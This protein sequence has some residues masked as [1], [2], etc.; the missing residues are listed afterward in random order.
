MKESMNRIAHN[1][2]SIRT[3]GSVIVFV[4]YNGYNLFADLTMELSALL[5]D[6]I[7]VKKV[8]VYM[9]FNENMDF[10]NTIEFVDTVFYSCGQ[11][12]ALMRR[13]YER[14]VKMFIHYVPEHFNS[15]DTGIYIESLKEKSLA[16]KIPILSIKANSNTYTFDKYLKLIVVPFIEEDC[17]LIHIGMWFKDE[18][19]KIN[20]DD[21]LKSFVIYYPDKSLTQV[22]CT[23][24]DDQ[25][26]D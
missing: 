6:C 16:Y 13:V 1:V 9:D 17:E 4:K 12:R 11:M 23:E 10:Y 5:N 18:H 21:L 19:L 7:N 8:H 15:G 14:T 25:N 26:N 22:M 3:K 24:K 2:Y 20:N